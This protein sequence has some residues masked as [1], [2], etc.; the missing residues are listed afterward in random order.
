MTRMSKKAEKLNDER[1]ERAFYRHCS[2]IQIDVMHLSKVFA[3]GRSAIANGADDDAL[4][5]ALLAFVN[6]IRRN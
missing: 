6:T 3:V 2:N 1:I 5:A 4:G